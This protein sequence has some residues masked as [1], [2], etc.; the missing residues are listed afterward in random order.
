MQEKHLF[1]WN[2]PIF[3]LIIPIQK[4]VVRCVTRWWSQSAITISHHFYCWNVCFGFCESETLKRS[5]AA[6][7]FYYI[8]YYGYI[9]NAG[10]LHVKSCILSHEENHPCWQRVYFLY[11]SPLNSCVGFV[12]SIF[13]QCHLQVQGT[14]LTGWLT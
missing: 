8:C 3:F 12:D 13:Q 2:D 10:E 4:L 6:T 7:H 9:Q 5:T 11:Y 1:S 14:I